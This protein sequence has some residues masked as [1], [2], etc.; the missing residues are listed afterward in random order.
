MRIAIIEVSEPNHYSA[1]NGLIKT[2]SS[3]ATNQVIV[4]TLPSIKVALEENGLPPNASIVTLKD[5]QA[6]AKLLASIEQNDFDRIHICTIFDNF[7]EFAKFRPNAEAIFLH[8]HQC[9]EW[10]NDTLN[11]AVKNLYLNLKHKDQ[12][13]KYHRIIARAMIDLIV[14]RPLRKKILKNYNENYQFSVIV[15]SEGQQETLLKYACRHPIIVFPFAIY[16]GMADAALP[17]Q[18]LKIGIPG[19]ISQAKR[20]YLGLF[21]SLRQHAKGLQG[22]IS[23][24]LIGYISDREKDEMQ[25]AISDLIAVG[26][27]VI[28][29]QSF[30]YGEEF[31]QAIASCDVLLNNQFI[32]KNNTEVYGQTKESGMIFNMLRAAKPGLLPYQYQVSQEFHS[33]TLFFNDYADLI[34]SIEMLATDRALLNELKALA[35]KLSASYLPDNLYPRLVPSISRNPQGTLLSPRQ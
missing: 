28:Y 17:T 26:Y 21:R 29:H 10:Y 6:L 25:S 33:S 4:Y 24:H 7:T 2:Y 12:N 15:H 19:I 1:V 35:K 20:D 32:S 22:K 34:R 8:V 23:L 11:R 3:I 9:E 14:F 18:P 27:D 30:V 31:D 16:E 13:R 5:R